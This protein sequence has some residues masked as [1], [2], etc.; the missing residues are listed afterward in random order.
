MSSKTFLVSK[1]Y[2][3]SPSHWP[4][5]ATNVAFVLQ[6]YEAGS[7]TIAAGHRLG[8]RV[9]ASSSSGADLVLL[10]D[11]PSHGSYLQVSG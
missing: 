3:P 8:M 9:W 5:S 7:A 11:H 2:S 6:L 1:G 4:Q 10:Y